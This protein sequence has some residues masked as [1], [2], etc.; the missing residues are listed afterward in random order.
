MAESPSFSEYYPSNLNLN[1]SLRTLEVRERV[2]LLFLQHRFTLSAL[3]TRRGDFLF[4]N[5][6]SQ[7]DSVPATTMQIAV[8]FSTLVARLVSSCAAAT[9][10]SFLLTKTKPEQKTTVSQLCSLRINNQR[11]VN[12][13]RSHFVRSKKAFRPHHW[14]VKCKSTI[15]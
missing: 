9:E 11:E 10:G 15:T 3:A 14:Q 5:S 7:A 1:S 4:F 6:N 2:M 12:S 13:Y 8:L